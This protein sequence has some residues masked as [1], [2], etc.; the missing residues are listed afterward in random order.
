MASR[1][2]SVMRREGEGGEQEKK[3]ER[4]PA[5]EIKKE[6]QGKGDQK[7]KAKERAK[8]AHGQMAEFYGIETGKG[9]LMSWRNLGQ[10]AG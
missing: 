6:G 4:M 8:R 5:K 2:D 9:K 1:V 3:T 7:G 10:G